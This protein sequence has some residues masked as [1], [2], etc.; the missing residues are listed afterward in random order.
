MPSVQ[1]ARVAVEKAL[2]RFDQLFSYL[3]P[4]AAPVQPGCRVL[5]PFGSGD[6]PRVGLVFALE[7]GQAQGLKQIAALLDPR[8]VLDAQGLSLALWLRETTFCTYFEAARLLL[9]LGA[10]L[11][12][13]HQYSLTAAGR[14][15]QPSPD[16]AETARLVRLLS[17]A[18]RPRTA[19]QAA[20]GL[21]WTEQ[22]AETLLN[23]LTEAGLVQ[24]DLDV[25]QR[26][27][28]ETALMLR[29]ADSF[30]SDTVRAPKQRRVLALLQDLGAASARELE[31]L[32]GCTRSV[33][34]TLHRKGA[35]VFYEQAVTLPPYD[36]ATQAE[37]I[38]TLPLTGA[39]QAAADG[40]LALA[41]TPKPCP[42]L[43]YGVTG[44]GKTSVFLH[45]IAAL[46]ADGKG[47]LVLVPEISLTAQTVAVFRRY[48]GA[49]VAVLH[50]G[51]AIGERLR[52]YNR[53]AAGQARVVIGTR[54]AVFAPV[55]DLGL[56]VLDEE[57][58]SSY[59]SDRTPM[60][61]AREVARYR[62]AQAGCLLLLASATPSIESYYA[63]QTGKYRLFT[64]PERFGAAR[65]PEVLLLDMR[66]Q[67][68]EGNATAFHPALLEAMEKTLAAGEQSILLL[69]R[70]GYHTVITCLDCGEVLTCPHCSIPMTYHR[71]NGRLLCHY[72]GCSQPPP[73]VC[74]HC[75]GAHLQPS[76]LGTQRA[77]EQL[78]A[79]LPQ[80]RIL[81][82]DADTT[83]N[84]QSY[85]QQFGRFAAGEY[86]V[87]LG[88]QMVA[89]GLN[90]PNATLVGV[91]SADAALYAQDFRSYEKAF[92]LFTQVVG[93]CG[94]GDKPGFAYIQT[95]TP[96][97][98]VFGLAAA[99]DYP[100][101]F[102][103]EIVNRRLMLY[104]PYCAFC[105]LVFSS[106]R[107]A[108][109]L[110]AARCFHALFT[111]RAAAA[112]PPAPVRVLGPSEG[113]V[114]KIAGRYRY[115][116]LVKNRG[117]RAF[118]ALLRAAFAAY[119]REDA[120]RGVTATADLYFD[121]VF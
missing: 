43:L 79:L 47:A 105:L 68:R 11:L 76:G 59:K 20:Q 84:R 121:G 10:G 94:R 2:P 5:V 82:M 92:A 37:S 9:P 56:I 117:D 58:D 86:D 16:E 60:Y 110:D 48:F 87:L 28:G 72:C 26:L 45:L 12:L 53:I 97:N 42:A 63:A 49:A 38:D 7:T 19:R 77:E 99:Q 64:L 120:S 80:A 108:A 93:R 70:R 4:A 61:H 98:P 109:A 71:A 78:A 62:C 95:G 39:Q 51:L 85:E 23:R 29:P 73:T 100:A 83:L 25:R 6:A 118:R 34:D 17:Q 18:N 32:A 107:Q 44:S 74:A 116:I 31:Y 115:K 101:F 114:L 89:K 1:I 41:R 81:R 35:V 66:G 103:D 104:P 106:E 13:E 69:N 111:A 54:S 102:R 22:T 14:A 57:Q 33:L 36:P 65:L 52:E 30:A 50:S 75:G 90:F 40:L 96:E 113:E 55:R 15:W 3:P 24:K 27:R 67:L 119:W 21:G 112:A 8:P 91:L 46:V 88:T